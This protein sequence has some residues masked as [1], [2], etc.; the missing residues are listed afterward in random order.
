MAQ[1]VSPRR[2]CSEGS[3]HLTRTSS[4]AFYRNDDGNTR[5]IIDKNLAKRQYHLQRAPNVNTSLHLDSSNVGGYGTQGYFEN[6][7]RKQ[8]NNSSFPPIRT[9][10][11]RPFDMF[12]KSTGNL[13]QEKVQVNPQRSISNELTT[14]Q[15]YPT[16]INTFRH[17]LGPNNEVASCLTDRSVS[18][19][20][21]IQSQVSFTS[22][23]DLTYSSASQQNFMT[24]SDS[25]TKYE[26][27]SADPFLKS[28]SHSSLYDIRTGDVL[29]WDR[30]QP[31]QVN[32]YRKPVNCVA[33]LPR[34]HQI[35]G[36]SGSIGGSNLQDIDNPA[37][38]FKP[39][40]ILR[41][42]QPKYTMN[43]SKPNI[44]FYTGHTHWSKI[45]PV[46]YHDQFGD[47]YT[48]SGDAHRPLPIDNSLYRH[49]DIHGIFSKSIINAM[50]SNPYNRVDNIIES[51][52]GSLDSRPSVVIRQLP[53]IKLPPRPPPPVI[54]RT[55]EEGEGTVN[56]EAKT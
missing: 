11:Q 17:E 7:V 36:Y 56:K 16:T 51:M 15:N 20:D 50:P 41:T 23:P 32:Y 19:D 44:P 4:D 9:A 28:Q 26:A 10:Y 40:T 52:N 46:S 42:N 3:S 24:K 13:T 38:D 45:G 30:T 18:N 54:I 34:A 37:V 35:S 1:V 12:R 22:Q 29:K 49:A 8:E 14:L 43:S 31:R 48:T 55:E 5:V 47:A 39:Y 33:P 21:Y 27:N 25:A 6:I 2:F 53:R